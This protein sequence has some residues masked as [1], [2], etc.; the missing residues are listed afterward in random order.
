MNGL[1]LRFLVRLTPIV[2]E[3]LS[4]WR[5]RSGIANDYALYPI[6]RTALR[7]VDPDAGA[8]TLDGDW[9]ANCC[10][11]TRDRITAMSMAALAN[12]VFHPTAGVGHPA[13]ILRSRY[14]RKDAASG[15]VYCALCLATDKRPYFRLE[16]RVGLIT[17]CSIHGVELSEKCPHCG[18]GIWP[19]GATRSDLFRD[20][21]IP[22]GHCSFCERSLADVPA[23]HSNPVHA[24]AL[25][26]MLQNDLHRLAPGIDV[27][28][29]E[30]V[31][32]LEALCRLFL[33]RRARAKIV[34]SGSSW[35]EVANGVGETP[36]G[37]RVDYLTLDQRR[38]L[39]HA[40]LGLLEDWPKA[41]LRFAQDT[42][43]TQEHFSGAGQHHP[44]WLES[45]IHENLR[46]QNRGVSNDDVVRT[47]AALR[48]DSA[49]VTKASVQI[50]LGSQA[51]AIHQHLSRREKATH[52][53][54]AQVL[55]YFE[56]DN[57]GTTGMR[58]VRIAR[59]RDQAIFLVAMLRR[60]SFAQVSA[61]LVA[62]IREFVAGLRVDGSDGGLPR[63][64]RLLSK[65]WLTYEL[66][67]E[68][69]SPVGLEEGQLHAARG[70]TPER[71]A[72]RRMRIAMAGL[73]KRLARSV[74]VFW[75]LGSAST[76]E[77]TQAGQCEGQIYS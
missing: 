42:G 40:T 6:P 21:R 52:H 64:T 67:A 65:R 59:C 17:E 53:E 36:A 69:I 45:V 51:S 48:A 58:S 44:P 71:S 50:A 70:G 57:D 55:D 60:W 27:R 11:V 20:R 10:D 54:L 23:W 63:V 37:A 16:W 35:S 28:T 18:A 46:R 43:I 74:S 3:S 38:L 26:A 47:I 5:Q 31:A 62:E 76:T 73:D 66:L 24:V 9:L 7:R 13:W 15:P 1:G 39:V 30:V 49:T 41:F 29:L 68:R 25:R 33:R 32:S 2:G 56:A 14:S 34:S 75:E 61:A 77:R 4:S 12:R 19:H 72:Q 22:F 8:N